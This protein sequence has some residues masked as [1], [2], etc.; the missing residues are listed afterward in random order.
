MA[1]KYDWLGAVGK[2]LSAG[3]ETYES[4][5]RQRVLE[6]AERRAEERQQRQLELEAQRIQRQ[7]D[8]ETQKWA[9]MEPYYKTMT[10]IEQTKLEERE[11]AQTPWAR[12]GTTLGKGARALQDAERQR[13][14]LELLQ[15]Q[16]NQLRQAGTAQPSLAESWPNWAVQQVQNMAMMGLIDPMGNLREDVTPEM[17]AQR[18]ADAMRTIATQWGLPLPEQMKRTAFEEA[19]AMV[20]MATT[21][22]QLSQ[23]IALIQNEGIAELTP[24]ENETLLA[25]A[26]QRYRE[27]SMAGAGGSWGPPPQPTQTMPTYQGGPGL[28]PGVIMQVP[29]RDYGLTPEQKQQILETLARIGRPVTTSARRLVTEPPYQPGMPQNRR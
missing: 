17:I 24:E 8:L 1:S 2:G 20:D 14:E 12:A 22:E 5:R 15:E 18:Q 27:M 26:L 16:I 7:Q 19:S 29:E 10:G 6:A 3:V 25:D 4:T 11:R 23:Q 21:P 28:R 13:L 9:T